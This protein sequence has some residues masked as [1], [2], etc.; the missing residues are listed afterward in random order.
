[1]KW[2]V[3]KW[4]EVKGNEIDSD[5]LEKDMRKRMGGF[6]AEREIFE[7]INDLQPTT[8]D[9]DKV[10]EQL[11]KLKEECADPL[12]E[13]NPEYFIDRAIE[14]VKAEKKE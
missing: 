13:Y 6:Q 12:Q 10:V 11:E 4:E 3:G 8:Y 7:S 1:M 14:I 2:F 9:V 5:A